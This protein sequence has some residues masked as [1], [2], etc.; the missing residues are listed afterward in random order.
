MPKYQVGAK[1]K[2]ERST[3]YVPGA[4]SKLDT[5]FALVQQH[6][7]KGG[8]PIQDA[9]IESQ[10]MGFFGEKRNFLKISSKG[11]VAQI[12]ASTYGN[13]LYI[14]TLV[15]PEKGFKIGPMKLF[16]GFKQNLNP[17]ELQDLEMFSY[18]IQK[19]INDILDNF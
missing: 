7:Q 15:L 3:F 5:I 12:Y 18:A 8:Y 13:D 6:V 10:K 1:G 14:M 17:F 2:F 11:E 9:R 16:S 4:A 19:V